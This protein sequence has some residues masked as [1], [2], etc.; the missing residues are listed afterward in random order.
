MIKSKQGKAMKRR[1]VIIAYDIQSNKRRR[2]AF[3]CLSSWKLNSQYSVFE[4][5]LTARE[6]EELF[7]T[8]SHIIDDSNDKLMLTWLDKTRQATALTK[9]T[10]L[11]FQS[12]SWYVG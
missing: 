11:G 12:A 6:A 9:S 8:L 4:C 7:L 5:L 10:N 1:K 3:K 2:K